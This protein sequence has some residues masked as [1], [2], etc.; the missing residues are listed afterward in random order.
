VITGFATSCKNDDE[1][2]EGAKTLNYSGYQ[3]KDITMYAAGQPVPGNYDVTQYFE[4]YIRDNEGNYS[5]TFD[6]NTVTYSNGKESYTFPY[7]FRNG[8]LWLNN[9]GED[10]DEG[11]Y[12]DKNQLTQRK[13]FVKRSNENGMIG[14]RS[15]ND[16]FTLEIMEKEGWPFSSL[17][18]M[19]AKDTL[20]WCNIDFIYK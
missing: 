8:K 15:R 14:M 2:A 3:V 6:G 13:A 19:G 16:Y 9:K 12:G 18:Q 7:E 4:E 20:I 11:F 1:G 17:S 5:L 10:V